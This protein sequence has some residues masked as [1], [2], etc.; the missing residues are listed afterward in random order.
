MKSRTNTNWLRISKEYRV[1]LLHMSLFLVAVSSVYAQSLQELE[2]RRK[3]LVGD[4]KRASTELT[5]LRQDKRNTLSEFSIFQKKVQSRQSLVDNL[6]REISILDA[7]IRSIGLRIDTITVSLER[8]EREY[9]KVLHKAYITKLNKSF[10]LFLFSADG[11]NDAIKRW[12]Y[13][14]QFAHFR[15]RQINSMLNLR[16]DLEIERQDFER[17]KSEKRHLLETHADQIRLLNAELARKDI[18]LNT[19]KKSERQL[20]AEL[21]QF[22]KAQKEL[23]ATIEKVIRQEIAGR[24]TKSGSKATG[25]FDD[26]SLTGP[27]KL[28]AD[29]RG[30]FLWP[31]KNGTVT[32]PFGR[33]SHSK[34][35]SVQITNNG[36]D[37]LAKNN[38]EV[39]SI[40]SG[41]VVGVNFIP[42]FAN[43]VIVEHGIFYTVYSNLNEVFVKRGAQVTA[44]QRLGA[45][46]KGDPQLHFELWMEKDRLNP[47][48]WLKQ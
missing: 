10:L 12:R 7:D 31:V 45:V 32:K 42:G 43:T 26:R 28:F 14:R 22:R 21:E 40:H 37:I 2:L 38:L 34:I 47:L 35:K 48:N 3:S 39:Y 1:A 20:A 5:E 36:V 9:S 25:T 44:Q 27:S 29:L 24:K 30:K 6:S 41:K 17:K 33:Q 23:D 15:K 19:L 16:S 4:I 46:K 13:I 11:F 18:L 8:H